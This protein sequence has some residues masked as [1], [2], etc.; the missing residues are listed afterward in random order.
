[1][2]ISVD[3]T[4]RRLQRLRRLRGSAR[5]VR[6]RLTAIYG[7]LFLLCGAALLTITYLLV[8]GAPFAPPLGYSPPA[9][10]GNVP[11][12]EA[13]EKHNVL[14]QLLVRS[15][16]A[17]AIMA[18]V[19]V[20]LGWVVA[21]RVLAPLRTITARTR[22]I[23]EANL[24]ERLALAGPDDE[25]KELSDT[26]DGLLSRL[27]RAFELQRRFV[28]NVSHELRTPLAMMRTSIDVADAKPTPISHDATVLSGKVREGLDQADRLVESFLALARAEVGGIGELETVSLAELATAALGDRADELDAFAVTARC[29]DAWVSGSRMLLAR[30]VANLLDNAVRYNRPGGAVAITTRAEGSLARLV[31]ENDGPVIDPVQATDLLEPFRR[32]GA[33]RTGS[34]TGVGLGL[35]IVAAIATAHGG[36]VDVRAREEGGLAVTVELPRVPATAGQRAGA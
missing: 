32:L 36:A 9:V 30:L 3:I 8:E 22:A 29:A 14:H 19:S 35:A 15:G 2:T 1:M 13:V 26:I 28:A 16:I 10:S 34:E 31:V 4:T 18:L 33:Y 7:S 24:D 12:A 17:L 20:W 25:I 11:M 23:S 6:A 21:G 27:E 5:S